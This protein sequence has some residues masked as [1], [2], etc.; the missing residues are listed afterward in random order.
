MTATDDK[1]TL[2]APILLLDEWMDFE[3]RESSSKV[4]DALMQIVETTGGVVLCATHKPNL[5]KKLELPTERTSQMAMC[6]GEI[7]TLRQHKQSEQ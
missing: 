4:E 1:L 3:T 5:W 2:P 7:L 6:R